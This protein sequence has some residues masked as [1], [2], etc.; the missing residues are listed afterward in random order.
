MFSLFF[1]CKRGF[2]EL[3]NPSLKSL[4]SLPY[5]LLLFLSLRFCLAPECISIRMN[6]FDG[7]IRFPDIL[8]RCECRRP[9]ICLWNTFQHKP[10]KPFSHRQKARSKACCRHTLVPTLS[11]QEYAVHTI[12][13]VRRKCHNHRPSAN[14]YFDLLRYYRRNCLKNKSFPSDLPR[15]SRFVGIICFLFSFPGRSTSTKQLR[16]RYTPLSG[17]NRRELPPTCK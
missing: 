8:G 12:S 4:F 14:G 1:L 6:R 7:H 10:C 9:P 16:R 17:R 5:Y 11:F 15:K 3:K 2:T 13:N